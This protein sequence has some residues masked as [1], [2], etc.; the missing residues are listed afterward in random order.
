[1]SNTVIRVRLPRDRSFIYIRAARRS[2]GWVLEVRHIRRR[3]YSPK[4]VEV[5][6]FRAPVQMS[7]R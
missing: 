7:G 5:M 1:M 3:Y 4:R 6:R 2:Y